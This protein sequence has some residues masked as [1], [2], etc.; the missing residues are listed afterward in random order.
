[1][2]TASIPICTKR[3][4]EGFRGQSHAA[5]PRP[6]PADHQLSRQAEEPIRLEPLTRLVDWLRIDP[7]AALTF[8]VSNRSKKLLEHFE[9]ELAKTICAQRADR[10]GEMPD[11][12]VDCLVDVYNYLSCVDEEPTRR[13]LFDTDVVFVPGVRRTLKFR[14]YRALEVVQRTRRRDVTV[15]FSGGQPAYE[16]DKELDYTEATA[17]ENFF[18]RVVS[19]S[20][21]VPPTVAPDLY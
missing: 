20:Y 8:P 3:R 16:G 9:W 4:G 7:P 14:I 13:T 17:L 19:E 5:R 6:A 18:K 12:L 11:D 2:S 21:D 15:V 10:G 1:M